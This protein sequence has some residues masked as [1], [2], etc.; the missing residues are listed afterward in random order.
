M[1]GASATVAPPI[2]TARTKCRRSNLPSR[3]PL[4]HGQEASR[5]TICKFVIVPLV[6]VVSRKSNFAGHAVSGSATRAQARKVYCYGETSISSVGTQN[7]RFAV[8]D[9]PSGLVVL[10]GW[11]TPCARA[12]LPPPPP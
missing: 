6:A 8:C 7:L 2:A 9:L 3:R 1:Y 4:Q 5:R 12:L 10:T 11:P